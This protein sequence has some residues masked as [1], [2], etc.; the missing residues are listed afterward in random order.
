MTPGKDSAGYALA[1]VL[2]LPVAGA[3][4]SWT[5]PTAQPLPEDDQTP[6]EGK[7]KMVLNLAT[8]FGIMPQ[9]DRARRCAKGWGF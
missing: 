6:M 2:G 7:G 1:L 3:E 8:F 5:S 9:S 4:T